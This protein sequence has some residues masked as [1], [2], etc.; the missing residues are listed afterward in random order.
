MCANLQGAQCLSRAQSMVHVSH[1]MCHFG[2]GEIIRWQ[3]DEA[4]TDFEDALTINVTRVL[5]R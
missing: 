4:P 5:R 2:M 3:M 1:A